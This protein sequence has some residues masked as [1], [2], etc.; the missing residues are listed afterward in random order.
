VRLAH[1]ETCSALEGTDEWH[2]P[3]A[4]LPIPERLEALLSWLHPFCVR[5]A[6]ANYPEEAWIDV[7]EEIRGVALYTEYY[8]SRV[9]KAVGE[10]RYLRLKTPRAKATYLA[11]A[12]ALPGFAPSYA[13]QKL[14]GVRITPT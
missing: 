2:P 5:L 10:A 1:G 3:I 12:L 8:F 7:P 6:E 13:D 14:R 11:K 4:D 9:M